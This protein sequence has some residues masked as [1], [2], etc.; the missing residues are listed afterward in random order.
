VLLGFCLG[1]TLAAEDLKIGTIAVAPFGMVGDDG[2]P[3]GMMYDIANKIA[4]TAGL[5]Y[6]NTLVPYA[7]S[8]VSL[9]EGLVDVVLRFNNAELPGVST[10]LG[11]VATMP[12]IILSKKAQPFATLQALRGKTVGVLKGGVFDDRFS[13]DEAIL[14][15][16]VPDYDQMIRML[17]AGRFDAAIGSNVGLYYVANKQGIAQDQLGTPLVLTTQDFLVHFSKKNKDERVKE[18]LKAAI[19]SLRKD[20]TFEKIIDKYMGGY[21]WN[22]TVSK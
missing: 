2:K 5:K 1:G 4:E 11:S 20:G 16:E 9:G 7:R 3:T 14:K 17:M 15:Q 18:A 8:V 12:T 6:T 21:H 10:P 22:V 19:E 13:K